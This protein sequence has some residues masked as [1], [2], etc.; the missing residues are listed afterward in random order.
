VEVKLRDGSTLR[1]RCDVPRGDARL[2]LT[3]SEL[4]SKFRDCL[5]FAESNWSADALLDR[6]RSL[7]SADRVSLA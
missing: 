6:L 2:P 7:R 3:D 5:T 4:E 1:E